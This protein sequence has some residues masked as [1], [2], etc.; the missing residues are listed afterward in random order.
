M[1]DQV[2]V[3]LPANGLGHTDPEALGCGFQAVE[4]LLAQ[5]HVNPLHNRGLQVNGLGITPRGD[6]GGLGVAYSL[7]ILPSHK[8]W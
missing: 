4:L 1:L 3:K 7:M 5:V 2:A 6:L 8:S